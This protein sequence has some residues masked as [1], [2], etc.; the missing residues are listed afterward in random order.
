[1]LCTTC[2]GDKWLQF[3]GVGHIPNSKDVFAIMNFYAGFWCHRVKIVEVEKSDK[4]R[5]KRKKIVWSRDRTGNG[6][7]KIIN[8]QERGRQRE[9][10]IWWKRKNK[11]GWLVEWHIN[12]CSLFNTKF[13]LYILN[14]YDF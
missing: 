6:Y 10:K 12:P 7:K 5:K 2:L 9:S 3:Y 14:V 13:C 4:E 11:I 8:K 1:M